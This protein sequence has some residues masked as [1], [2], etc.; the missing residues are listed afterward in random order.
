MFTS[1]NTVAIKLQGGLGNQLFQYAAGFAL[2]KK[3]NC[4][5][6]LDARYVGLGANRI[7]QLNQLS[8]TGELAQYPDLDQF[9]SSDLK[10]LDRKLIRRKA[11]Y[12]QH[13]RE[14]HF[15][16]DP[17]F[18]NLNGS[19]YLDGYWQS[20]RYFE[21]YSSEIKQEFSFRFEQSEKMKDSI[22]NISNSIA[23]HIRRG[24]YVNNSITNSYHGNL[25]LHYYLSA[26]ERLKR[27]FAVDD[28]YFFT[29]D[30]TWVSQNFRTKSINIISSMGF[31]DVEEILVFSAAKYKIISNSSFSW[32]G[33][34]LGQ[35]KNVIAPQ[36]WFGLNVHNDTSDLYQAHWELI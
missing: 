18:K 8:I 9:P 22:S 10:I 36:N 26:I 15:H 6:L 32:W 14:P 2:S 25:N 20:A 34:W 27:E 24:D 13:V 4:K 29:D 17:E 21:T 33:A 19:V 28:V 31:S 23:V 3:L 12:F 30:P 35:S 5:L 7:Y 11:Q 16:Y 1:K